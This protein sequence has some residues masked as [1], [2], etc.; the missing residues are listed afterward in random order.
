MQNTS[1][2]PKHHFTFLDFL[3]I[4]IVILLAVG[5]SLLIMR[6]ISAQTDEGDYNITYTLT[7]EDVAPSLDQQFKIGQSVYDRVSG[8][9]IGVIANVEATDYIVKGQK[10][11]D[12]ETLKI[13]VTASAVWDERSCTVNEY[14][15]AAGALISFRTSSVALDALCTSLEK[16]A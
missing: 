7:A 5:L 16:A 15:L 8:V 6:S 14:R 12:R 3:L 9:Q 1:V 11:D 4:L 13:T 2:T 10:I